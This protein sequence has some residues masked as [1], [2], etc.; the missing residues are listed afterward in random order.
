[1]AAKSLNNI[2]LLANPELRISEGEKATL[3]IGQRIPVPVTTFTTGVQTGSFGSLPATSYQYQDVGIKVAIEPRVHHNQEVTLKLTVEVSNQGTNAQGTGTG[4]VPAQPTFI[5][6]TIEST[7]RLKDGETNFLAGLIQQ[8]DA[9]DDQKTPFL[10]DLPIIGRLFTQTS[11]HVLRTD[12]VLTMTP[13]IIRMPNITEDD[14]APMWVGTQN[15]LTFRGL[16]PRLESRTNVDPFTPRAGMRD[17]NTGLVYADGEPGNYIQPSPQPPNGRAAPPAGTPPNDPF[18]R[19][20]PQPQPPMQQPPVPESV[21]VQ[22]R[23]QSVAAVGDQSG[24]S[25]R[26]SPQPVRLTVKPGE[27]KLWTIV[28]MDLD[29]LTASEML[30]HFDPR[31]IDVSEVSFGPAVQIDLKKPPVVNIDRGSG[32]IKVTS[33]DGG[34][35]RF[36][37]GG[38]IAALRVRGVLS[39]ETYLVLESPDLK[40]ATG[41][42][43]AATIAGGHAKVE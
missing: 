25:P 23:A 8:N 32:T 6:R 2:E 18:R 3:H 30:L 41:A 39:G 40:N 38:D 34:P 31:T 24:L 42:V 26:M 37:S 7:I 21:N 12:L 14:L 27:E 5:T 29:G 22:P 16:S 35:L 28:G 17:P 1:V 33:S 20:Q 4:G 36:N 9:Q 11:K 15:N 43:V 10:G 19:T 13:H